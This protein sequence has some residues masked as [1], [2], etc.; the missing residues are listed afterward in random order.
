MSGHQYLCGPRKMKPSVGF[1]SNPYLYS[2]LK[3][4]HGY[5]SHLTF[6]SQELTRK[7]G[8]SKYLTYLLVIDNN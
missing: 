3:E 1:A 2:I 5:S 8:K 7:I 6:L 4:T